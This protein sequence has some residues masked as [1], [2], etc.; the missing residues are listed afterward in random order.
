V[1]SII[2]HKFFFNSKH[3]AAAECVGRCSDILCIFAGNEFHFNCCHH[4]QF[5]PY[6][7]KAGF[8]DTDISVGYSDFFYFLL[9][10][11]FQSDHFNQDLGFLNNLK[12][13]KKLKKLDS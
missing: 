8:L 13:F 3:I 1:I 10:I 7:S 12:N 5:N 9:K 11:N 4:P 6:P 2:S